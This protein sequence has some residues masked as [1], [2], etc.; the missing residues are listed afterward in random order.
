MKNYTTT[1]VAKITGLKIRT[2]IRACVAL[3]ISKFGWGYSIPENRIED[4]KN[5]TYPAPG[6]PNW[7]KKSKNN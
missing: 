4:I 5:N 2:V 1:E 3:G 6:N 7:K